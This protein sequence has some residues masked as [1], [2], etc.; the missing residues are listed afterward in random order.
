MSR[1]INKQ[2]FSDATTVTDSSSFNNHNNN[3]IL[4][5]EEEGNFFFLSDYMYGGCLTFTAHLLHTLNRKEVFRIAKRFERRKRN[6]GYGI[7]YQNVTLEYFDALKN[8]FITDIFQHFECLR[9]L[10]RKGKEEVTIVIHDPGEISKFNKP[11]LKYWNII[12]IRKSMQ[13]F[14]RDRYGIDSK[15]IYHPFYLYPIQQ[16]DNE[17]KMYAVSISRIDFN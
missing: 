12:T 17:Q 14:I 16:A 3:S 9:K 7:R 11:Y 13:Q 4:S 10:K 5:Q 6:L 15:F 2:L 8:I 1:A